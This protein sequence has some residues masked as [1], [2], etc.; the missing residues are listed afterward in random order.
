MP[1]LQLLPAAIR[2][3][4]GGAVMDKGETVIAAMVVCLVLILLGEWVLVSL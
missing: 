3:G 2:G 4:E 1:A